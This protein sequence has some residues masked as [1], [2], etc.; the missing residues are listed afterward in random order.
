MLNL[1]IRPLLL[2]VLGNKTAMTVVR[3]F[4][5]TKQAAAML[6]FFVRIEDLGR[7]REFGKVNIID[8][9]LLL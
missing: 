8:C 6:R 4:L 3:P 9:R 7:G 1:N 2:E 5:T